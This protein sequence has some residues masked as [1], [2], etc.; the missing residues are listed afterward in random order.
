MSPWQLLGDLEGPTDTRPTTAQPVRAW[1]GA[2]RAAGG[3]RWG[4]AAGLESLA[5]RELHLAMTSNWAATRK[6]EVEGPAGWLPKWK[7]M[8]QSKSLGEK[9]QNSMTIPM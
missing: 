9:Q 2:L 8:G 4:Q 1:V 3:G 6:L 5:P 7:E